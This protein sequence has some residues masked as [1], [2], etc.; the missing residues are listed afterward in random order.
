MINVS[1]LK[2]AKES[3][4]FQN[5]EVSQMEKKLEKMIAVQKMLGRNYHNLCSNITDQDVL[6]W[7]LDDIG[8]LRD[9]Y[10]SSYISVWMN[11][12]VQLLLKNH[13]YSLLNQTILPSIF[14]EEYTKRQVINSKIIS[15][16]GSETKI[17]FLELE[18]KGTSFDFDVIPK[19]VDFLAIYSVASNGKI[20]FLFSSYAEGGDIWSMIS[21]VKDFFDGKDEADDILSVVNTY[22]QGIGKMI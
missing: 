21:E 10:S 3:L 16:N 5:D 15:L 14:G 8:F 9:H 12:Y 22:Y 17:Y 1:D 11:P 7:N 2:N 19:T 6:Q 13:K 18:A 4:V 20:D